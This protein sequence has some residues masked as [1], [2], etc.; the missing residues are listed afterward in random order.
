[1][2]YPC[3]GVNLYLID[4]MREWYSVYRLSTIR[5]YCHGISLTG[6]TPPHFCACPK[7]GPGFPTSY[8]VFFSVQWAKVTGNCSLCWC[9]CN[10]WPS[11]FINCLQSLTLPQSNTWDQFII[12][13]ACHITNIV[14]FIY[15]IKQEVIVRKIIGQHY[16][17]TSF[18]PHNVKKKCD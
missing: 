18:V 10:C 3:L 1:V 6:L 5:P 4:K 2:I 13:R 11:L 15:V 7:P 12:F 17:K 9:Q 8:V 16:L 14:F